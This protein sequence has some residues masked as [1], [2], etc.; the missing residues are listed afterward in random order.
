MMRSLAT[1]GLALA[2]MG[3]S[4]ASLAAGKIQPPGREIS[5]KTPLYEFTYSYPAAAGRIPA[6]KA[7]LDKDAAG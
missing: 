2:L 7:W 3:A 6:L 4:T 5:V 1:T